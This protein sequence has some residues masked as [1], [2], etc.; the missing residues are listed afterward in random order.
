MSPIE[1]RKRLD[2]KNE[3]LGEAL[4]ILYNLLF[5]LLFCFYLY[6]IKK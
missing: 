4:T 2:R 1:T 3:R 6:K 5:F